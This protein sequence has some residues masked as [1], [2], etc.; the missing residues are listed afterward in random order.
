MQ[1]KQRYEIL[2]GMR[3]I[4]AIIVMLFHYNIQHG[5]RMFHNVFTAVDFF[6]ILSGFVILH[7]YGS[8]IQNGMTAPEFHIRRIARLLPLTAVGVILGL[9]AFLILINSSQTDFTLHG[10]LGVVARN[11]FFMP[12]M[13]NNWF[14]ADGAKITGQL[15]P[16]DGPLWSI[17]F[18]FVIGFGFIYFVRWKDL[19]LAKLCALSFTAVVSY[20]LWNGHYVG[21]RTFDF[22]AGWGNNNFIGGFARVLFGF[23]CGMLIYR[24]T[25]SLAFPKLG[26]KLGHLRI[27]NAGLIYSA[28]ILMLTFP[29]YI[30]GVYSLFEIGF[31]APLL[32]VLGSRSTCK[33]L[34]MRRVSHY[35]GVLSFPLYCL[36]YPIMA[37]LKALVT[38]TNFCDPASTAIV[39]CA[40]L[41]T[42]ISSFCI[43]TVLERLAVQKRMIAALDSVFVKDAI[44][45]S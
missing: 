38:A 23:T 16:T 21:N 32:V 36:H 18:E 10:I 26:E 14:I 30:K 37:G 9:P 8:K 12:A 1:G 22:D 44:V 33:T 6:F 41:I 3:G 28:L 31:L 42:L 45:V 7:S 5:Y 35:L 2:D 20:S 17:F 27:W 4:A 19:A 24:V 13:N 39:I 29:F 25:N 43:T 34:F 40:I 11:I 15:F